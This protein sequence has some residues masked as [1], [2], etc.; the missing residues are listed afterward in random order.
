MGIPYREGKDS[1]S[2]W[3]YTMSILNDHP[4]LPMPQGNRWNS[5]FCERSAAQVKMHHPHRVSEPVL[6]YTP[7]S[8]E[9][10]Q[11]QVA[12]SQHKLSTLPRELKPKVTQSHIIAGQYR[13]GLSGSTQNSCFWDTILIRIVY[14]LSMSVQSNVE[15]S[16]R[17]SKC[18][19]SGGKISP[20]QNTTS[21][22]C[23]GQISTPKKTLKF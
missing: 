14:T 9:L 15:I 7:H 21:K 5:K 19:L 1:K 20:M 10:Y 13:R 18:H 22:S 2:Q 16:F 23:L 3:V 11:K 6:F 4:F 8:A 12:T 17:H